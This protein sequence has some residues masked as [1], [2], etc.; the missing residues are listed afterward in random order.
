M[1]RILFISAL[2]A[3]IACN[4]KASADAS[5]A[6]ADPSGLKA[7]QTDLTTIKLSWTDNTE[8][9]KGY[10][11]FRRAEGEAYNVSPLALIDA[12]SATFIF[13]GLVNGSIYDFGVQA[14]SDDISLHS[15]TVWLNNCK[16]MSL[17]ELSE[18]QNA[19]K[20]A[21]PSELTATQEDNKTAKLTWK[22]NAGSES[23]YN[24]FIRESSESE[25]GEIKATI[26][27]DSEEYT[28]NGLATGAS[29]VFGVQ[30]A[31]N[32]IA[33]SSSIATYALT[34]KDMD[35]CPEVTDIRTSHA[36]IAVRYK[37]KKI[38]GSAPEH[39]ICFSETGTPS[40]KDIKTHSQELLP[41]PISL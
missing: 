40:V 17:Q 23:G 35:K 41:S 5:A 10:R 9:E 8:G 15:K 25:F 1:K 38:N 36:Y 22:D 11:V 2:A 13:E 39:G 14:I 37:V 16:V 24:I 3:V 29:Y 20:L 30:A 28:F 12:E 27:A 7:E 31:S 34:L 32:T 19:N 6:L 4:E 21:A 26:P 18:Q 33:N